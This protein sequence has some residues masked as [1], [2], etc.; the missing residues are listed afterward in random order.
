VEISII[1]GGPIGL[2]AARA[3]LEDGNQ[4]R[5]FD[6]SISKPK[7]SL[8]L[9]ESTLRLLESIG[10][11]LGAGQDLTEIL[12]NE[13]GLP[14]SILLNASECGYPRFGRV[15][16]SQALEE[17]VSLHVSKSVET[18]SVETIRARSAQANPR[19]QLA[20]GE[21][22]TPDLVI[23]ADGGRSHLTDSLGLE[24]QHRPFG[25]SAILGR[26]RVGTPCLGRAYERFIGTGPLALL[27]V[28]NDVYGFVWSLNPDHAERLQQSAS[29]LIE[30]LKDAIP[31]ELGSIEIASD[32]VL[33]PLV[34]RWIDQPYR[35][36]IVLIGN[37][38]QTIHP[39]A[40]QGLNFA[41]RGVMQ[42]TAEL[43]KS[44]PDTAVRTA[45]ANWKPN[46]DKTRLASSSLEALFDRDVFPR[47]ILTSLGMAVADQ[48]PWL[49]TKIAEA[50]M[51]VVS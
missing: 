24:A 17:A 38:A 42:L 37:G 10:V 43:K 32:P 14:G 33:I 7:M 26:F 50:G 2:I 9:A 44:D 47:K 30:A 29:D 21:E 22:V 51:G 13:K 12:V 46:R 36:G 41:L 11:E 40:G 6:P 28:E 48:S 31:E 39:V 23:L 20:T 4:V 5:L 15:V 19:I 49:K 35:P 34:E 1:G 25:R 8:A 18:V 45:F 27:P 16:C 3:L